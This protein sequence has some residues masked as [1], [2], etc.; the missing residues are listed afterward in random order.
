MHNCFNIALRVINSNFRNVNDFGKRGGCFLA[1]TQLGKNTFHLLPYVGGSPFSERN[2]MH[3]FNFPI[4]FV[5]MQLTHSYCAVK[6]NKNT[7]LWT[8]FRKHAKE[9]SIAEMLEFIITHDFFP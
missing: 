1:P 5:H 4:D 3:S 6:P 7:V 2:V 8:S 9:F